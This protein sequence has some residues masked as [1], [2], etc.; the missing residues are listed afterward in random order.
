MPLPKRVEHRQ[1]RVRRDVASALLSA[2]EGM[3]IPKGRR[4]GPPRDHDVDPELAGLRQQLQRHSAHRMPDREEKIRLAERYLRIER[5]N[6]QIQQKVAA[7]TNSLARTFDRIVVLLTER[8]F[9]RDVDGDPKVTDDGRLLARIYSE[10]DLLVAECLR[11]GVWEGLAPAELAGVLSSVLYESRGDSAGP[12]QAADIPTGK[13]RRALADTRRLAAELRADEQRHRISQSREPDE[14][15][16]AAVHRWAT[17]GDL[18]SALDASDVGR[19]GSPMSAGDFVRWCRQVLDLA[20][21]VRNAARTAELRAAA[22]RAI[23]DVR[24]GVVAVDAG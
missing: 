21:Q 9:I 16:V 12:P 7:A 20:D 10:S 5:D 4:S 13:L 15:F 19:S 1:P 23:A 14:G 22:K 24:R 2:T 6:E 11:A 8:G 18:A 3:S 17:T